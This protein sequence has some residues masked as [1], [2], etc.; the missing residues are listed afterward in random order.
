[1]QKYV[2]FPKTPKY[3][4]IKKYVIFPKTPKYAKIC[5]IT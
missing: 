2:I 1:M 5:N 4:K 3:A